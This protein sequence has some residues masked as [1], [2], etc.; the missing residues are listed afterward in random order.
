LCPSTSGELPHK[1]TLRNGLEVLIR[2]AGPEDFRVLFSMFSSLSDDTM[3]RRFLRS[4]KALT[5]ANAGEMLQL[6][7]ANV[8]SLI[9]IVR[10]DHAEQAV[11]E[12]RYV[13]NSSGELAEAA[14]VVA[15]EWQN[16]GL[17]TALFVDLLT[18][19]K[20]AG[21]SK[22]I[23]Y[24]DVENSS[25]IHLGQKFGFKLAPKEIRPDYSMLK[26]EITI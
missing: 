20:R 26:A 6:D 4:Q 1:V 13:T 2:R 17:G 18:E 24:F 3:F 7:G 16:L 22:I 25:V 5:E 19:A 9:A 21:L 11:G 15:D 8:T 23:A 10:K 12:A 14:V